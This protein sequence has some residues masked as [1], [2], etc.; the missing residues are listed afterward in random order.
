MARTAVDSV[1]SSGSEPASTQEHAVSVLK[2]FAAIAHKSA[3]SA[4][5]PGAY[6]AAAATANS[7]TGALYSI[8]FDIPEAEWQSVWER[9]AFLFA[10]VRL[11][12]EF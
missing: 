5:G 1:A 4:G 9:G 11:D 8:R 10:G 12:D 2:T 6:V 7:V 3:D